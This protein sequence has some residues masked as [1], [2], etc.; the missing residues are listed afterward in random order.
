MRREIQNPQMFETDPESFF[1]A[2]YFSKGVNGQTQNVVNARTTVQGLFRTFEDF[3]FRAAFTNR[4]NTQTFADVMAKNL[5][6]PFSCL[7]LV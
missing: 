4:K 5:K 6:L 7:K 2:I 1:P 3:E